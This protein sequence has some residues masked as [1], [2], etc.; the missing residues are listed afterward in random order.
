MNG[1]R[2]VMALPV[3][4]VGWS[5]EQTSAGNCGDVV[6]PP[7]D[8][9]GVED[10]GEEQPDEWTC[11]AGEAAMAFP[12]MY[13]GILER[14]TTEVPV[15][16]GDWG[17]DFGDATAF[18]PPALL[19]YGLRTCNREM[20]RLAEETLAHQEFLVRHF[21]EVMDGTGAAEVLIGGIGLIEAYRI[22]SDPRWADAARR[23]LDDL[24]DTAAL[25]G[26]YLYS[27]AIDTDPYGPTAVTGI[28]AAQL[29]RFSEVVDPTDTARVDRALEIAAAID[30]NAWDAA[31]GFYKA[32]P[33]NPQLDL[34]PNVAMMIVWTLAHRMTGDAAHLAR[35]TALYD[36]LQPL[37][38]DALGAYHSLYSSTVPD[39][40]SLSSQNYL[41]F[42]LRF[43]DEET[44]DPR[45]MLEANTILSFIESHLLWNRMAWHHWENDARATW[46]CTGCNFQLLY[47]LWLVGPTE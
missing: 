18:A 6:V 37:R 45:Y 2:T 25:F 13:A 42:A 40:V 21:L 39:Y 41:V 44:G 3:A 34:Y 28:V 17:E 10:A 31:G 7:D 14:L 26:D 4:I 15:N 8:G 16:E 33:D 32:A 19:S 24:E 1:W 12:E 29:L 22:T 38:L 35:A 20:I 5:C 11:E 23:L 30:R 36:A 47:D 43:L 27:P 9:G 46:Y